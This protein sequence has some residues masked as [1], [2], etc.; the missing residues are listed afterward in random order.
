MNRGGSLISEARSVLSSASAKRL[1]NLLGGLLGF[2]GLVAVSFKLW[3]YRG[4]LN[5]AS[6]NLVGYI[7]IVLAAVLSGMSNTLLA[8]AWRSFLL[9]LGE[10]PDR[11]WSI[12]AYSTSQVAKYVP[13]N[14]FHYTS[15]QVIGSAAGLRHG[16]LFK[17]AGLELIAV[18]V[19]AVLFLPLASKIFFPFVHVLFG[20]IV[21]VLSVSIS[22]I[23]ATKYAGRYFGNAIL[24]YLLFLCISAAIFI[25]VF[26]NVGGIVT[27]AGIPLVVGAYVLSWLL[28]LVTPGAPAG[29]GVRE[30]TLLYLLTGSAPPATIL[31]AVVLG[32]VITVAGDLLFYASG[33]LW[34]RRLVSRPV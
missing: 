19:V 12:W 31:S 4:E 24:Y 10:V 23:T 25:F 20:I 18:A 22:L 13:G 9:Y 34:K 16:S 30:A 29:I 15:R 27:A 3:A 1:L 8:L 5:A 32:R 28:G 21:F 17:S 33:Q 11:R 26:I 7:S 14:I 2:A 6:L